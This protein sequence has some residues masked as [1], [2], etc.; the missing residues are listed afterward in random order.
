MR[1]SPS[2]EPA[3]RYSVPT[4]PARD[5]RGMTRA[6][7]LLAIEKVIKDVQDILKA[8]NSDSKLTNKRD[9]DGGGLSDQVSLVF[10]PIVSL[11]SDDALNLHKRLKAFDGSYE[12]SSGL[13]VYT[14]TVSIDLKRL[15]EGLANHRAQPG[16]G[17]GC[18]H[19]FL[20][21]VLVM[22]FLVVWFGTPPTAKPV[23]MAKLLNKFGLLY[24]ELVNHTKSQ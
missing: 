7:Q 4:E 19:C 12:L 2:S 20:L 23:W 13:S 6:A 8:H 11:T 18:G 21:L 16:S 24:Q 1:P 9:L 15:D 17:V 3:P 10:G 14:L 5:K 22:V